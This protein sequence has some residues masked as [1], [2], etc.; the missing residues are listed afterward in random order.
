MVSIS[1]RIVDSRFASIALSTTTQIVG[2]S[3]NGPTS[4]TPRTIPC[5]ARID[6]TV[7]ATVPSVQAILILPPLADLPARLPPCLRDGIL[8]LRGEHRPA[9]CYPARPSH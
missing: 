9:G 7:A 1:R 8:T 5:F 3:T 6:F 2:S 4:V